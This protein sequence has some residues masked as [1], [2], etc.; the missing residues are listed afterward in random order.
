MNSIFV[1]KTADGFRIGKG[2]SF[3]VFMILDDN[4]GKWKPDKKAI[5]IAFGKSPVYEDQNH[6][7]LVAN[8]IKNRHPEMDDGISILDKFQNASYKELTNETD[9]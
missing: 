1:L 9:C 8:E 2:A 3:H 4:T 5:K 7:L 6:A